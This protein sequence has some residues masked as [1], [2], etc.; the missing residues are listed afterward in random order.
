MPPGTSPLVLGIHRRTLDG[1]PDGSAISRLT[2]EERYTAAITLHVSAGF[3]S[4]D[5][6]DDLATDILDAS[7]RHKVPPSESGPPAESS[8]SQETVGSRR[9][10]CDLAAEA[11]AEAER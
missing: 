10:C 6:T 3:E 7:A 4:D 11:F 9:S 1:L 2:S 8:S 5:E